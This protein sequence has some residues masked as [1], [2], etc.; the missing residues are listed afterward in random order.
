MKSKLYD[1]SFAQ[2]LTLTR[3]YSTNY[4][5]ALKS[6]LYDFQS[7]R[8]FYREACF[9]SGTPMSRD[10]I[11]TYVRLQ[12]LII[13]PIA[14]HWAE[15]MWLEVLDNK[16][17][18]QCA[19]WPEVPAPEAAL[20]AAREYVKST[21]SNITSAEATA[22]K[23]MAKGK[24]TAFD[25]KKP[26]RLTIFAAEN[27]PDW[28]EKY[29]DLVR[30]MFDQTSLSIDDKE[31]NAQVAKMGKGAEMKKAMP[32][33]Q[34]LRKRLVGR[35]NPKAVLERMLPFNEVEILNEMKKGL[36]RTTGCKEVVVE[37]VGEDKSKFSQVA[38][39]A[40]PGQP[41]FLFENITE[42]TKRASMSAKRSSMVR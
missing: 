7:A 6:A 37:S 14:P 13:T 16:E 8:D 2:K 15:Y 22:A 29:I 25:P 26:K 4:K 12:S 3:F 20:T 9:S 21:A 5:L 10:L 41:T 27:F 24:A 18:I 40:I 33:V 19:Q 23:K 36:M 11:K 39:S 17:T 38:E 1:S 30:E 42:P 28:Q 31:L 32:F 34:G 35:E